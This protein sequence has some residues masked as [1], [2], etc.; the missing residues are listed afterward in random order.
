MQFQVIVVLV[1][2][3]PNH[4]GRLRQRKAHA[5]LEEMVVSHTNLQALI[6]G[7]G[8]MYAQAFL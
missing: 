1:C 4:I 3:N 7:W 6:C 8:T 2:G 5:C